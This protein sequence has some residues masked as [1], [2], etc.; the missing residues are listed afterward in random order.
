MPRK[1]PFQVAPLRRHYSADLKQRVIH[2]AYTLHRRSEDITTDLDMP[3]RVVQR[4]K[5]TWNEIGEVCRDWQHQGRAPLLSVHE[6]RFMLALLEHSPDIYL[7]KIQEQ[8]QEQ[9][10]FTASLNTISQT[11]K[12]L[13][14]SSKK[15]SRTAAERC[16]EARNAFALEIGTYPA[17]YLVAGDKVAINV[18]TTY[19]ANGW[20]VQGL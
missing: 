13:G 9:H 1:R 4:V 20:S 2:Q 11:L 15:L 17:E 5:R 7:D 10:N 19:R 3:L 16:Q 6:T 18:L 14:I 12:R 8:L